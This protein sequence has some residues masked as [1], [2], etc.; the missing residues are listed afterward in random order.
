MLDYK[1]L[2]RRH[3]ILFNFLFLETLITL[4]FFLISLIE[5]S[6]HMLNA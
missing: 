5:W 4:V 3:C 2:E 1:F 6:L